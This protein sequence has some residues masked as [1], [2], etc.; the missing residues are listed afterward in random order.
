MPTTQDHHGRQAEVIAAI[1]AQIHEG[2]LLPGERLPA[3][4]DLA[5]S[6]GLDKGTVV[7]AIKRLVAMGVV[8]ME[9]DGS[10]PRPVVSGRLPVGGIA[11]G[12]VL[13][14]A[15]ASGHLEQIDPHRRLAIVA[16]LMATLHAAHLPMT[17][18][19]A[20]WLNRGNRRPAVIVLLE[21]LDSEQ[22][23][24]VA[25]WQAEGTAVICG[26]GSQPLPGADLVLH[27]HAAGAA[28]LVRILHEEGRRR[29]L[30]MYGGGT[31]ELPWQIARRQG[32][33]TEAARLGLVLLEPIRWTG[34]SSDLDQAGFEQEVRTLAG[35]AIAQLAGVERADGV[36][37]L[38]DGFIPA[39]A[40]VCDRLGRP[41]HDEVAITGYDGYWRNEPF[42]TFR[43]QPPLATID[44]D[45]RTLGAEMAKLAVARLGGDRREPQ[46]LVLPPRLIDLR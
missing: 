32:I 35:L 31:D 34:R 20:A 45:N 30:P 16:G 27:D 46:R 42:Q 44:K 12:E 40:T 41:V 26:D 43:A 10:R 23:A 8:R 39:L 14:V 28:A 36:L 15:D 13:T 24:L 38:S 2:T 19:P 22:R 25:A 1:K 29:L 6:H 18:I 33:E 17:T 37:A 21:P 11:G 4:R 9:G 7:R 3:I 5:E